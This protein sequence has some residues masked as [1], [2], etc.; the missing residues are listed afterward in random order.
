MAEWR[1][2]AGLP[3][4]R[5]K[6]NWWIALAVVTVLA[7]CGGG[8]AVNRITYGDGGSA[9]AEPSTAPAS[10]PRTPAPSTP[11]ATPPSTSEGRPVPDVVRKRLSEAKALLAGAGYTSVK[12][13]DA[14]GAERMVLEDNNWLVVSQETSTGVVTL[15]VRKPTDGKGSTD[16]TVGV[17]PDVVCKELQAA[18]EALRS[19]RFLN[20]RSHDATGKGRFQLIDRDWVVV[21]QSEPPETSPSLTTKIVLQVVKYGEPTG[22]SGCES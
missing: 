9:D 13:V 14:T 6:R 18:Q 12:V 22:E 21:A 10:A 8:L 11:A 17:V 7:C 1:S 19:A 15:H 2:H 4:W 16:T 20:I 5:R 3:G